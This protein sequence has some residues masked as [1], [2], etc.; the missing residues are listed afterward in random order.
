MKGV[1]GIL[2]ILASVRDTVTRIY[3]P[4]IMTAQ[5]AGENDE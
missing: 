2:V 3:L 4:L 1:S 5:Q